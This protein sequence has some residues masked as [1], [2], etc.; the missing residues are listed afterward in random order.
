MFLKRIFQLMLI[1]L[2]PG[3]AA[4]QV[5]TGT[6]TGT[7]KTADGKIVDGAAVKAVHTPTGSV[8]TATSN[9]D[10]HFTLANVRVGGP[11]TLTVDYTGL[12]SYKV[13]D[14]NAALGTPLVVDVVLVEQSK[15]LDNVVVASSRNSIISSLHSGTAVTISSRQLQTLP[16]I[17]NSVQDFVRFMPQVKVGNSGNDGS[18]TGI[19]FGGQNNRY[20]QFT[21]DGANASDVFGLGSTGTNG[22]QANVNPISMEAIQELQVVM[23]PYDVAQGGFTGG[24]INAIT[25]SGTNK[26]HG[27]VY[28]QYQNQNFVGKSAGYNSTITRKDYGEFKNY[29]YGASL[30]GP[31][32]QNKLFFFANFEK[33]N[34]STPLAFDPTNS[35]SG[36]K[37]NPDTLE[38]IRQ[39]LISKYNYDPGSYGSI[40]NINKSTSVFARIDWNIDDKNKLMVRFNHVDGS[41]TI[42]SRSA[43][44][45]I[46]ANSGYGFT[47]K[48]NSFVAELNSQISSNAS[49]LLRIT[50]TSVRDARSTSRFPNVAI[51][52]FNPKDSAT[53][54]YNIGSDYSS[55]VNGLNQDV[56]T[57]TDNF[58]LY[59][60]NHTFTFGTNNTLYKSVNFF[61]QGYYGAYTYG[62]SSTTSS[63][64]IN[65][66]LNNTGLTTYQIGFSTSSTPGDKAPAT[67]KAGQFSLYAQDAWAITDKFRLTYGIRFDLPSFF[68]KPSANEAFASTFPG[69]TTNQMPKT[70]I[71]YS[72][73]V[74]FN[75]DVKGDAS[76]QL[77]GGAGLFTG[78]VPFVWV[79]N[80]ISNTGVQS[81]N[82]TYTG[83][84]ITS[85]NIT[86][87]ND[88]NSPNLGAF[89]P[90]AS[91]ASGTVINVID[92]KFKFPQVFRANLA[93]DQKLGFWGLIGTVEGV[94]TKTLNNANYQNINISQNGDSSVNIGP[95]SRPIWTK[96]SNTAYGNVLYL[97]NTSA[98]YGYNFT[99]QIQKPYS[100]GWSGSLAYT[101][102]HSTSLNDLTSS[103]AQSNWRSP[104][105]T[106]G[107]NNP[108]VSTSNFNMGSRIIGFISKEFRYANDHLSTTISLTYSGQ[109]GQ[110]FSYTYGNNILGDYTI[111]STSGAVALAYIPMGISQ[112][113]FVDIN[114]SSYKRTAAQQ[115]S[116]F[117]SFMLNNP[118]LKD[119]QGKVAKRNGAS[120]PWEN[121]FDVKISQNFMMGT[122]KLEVFFSV[123]NVGNM[124]NKNSGWSYG[125][126]SGP[127]GFYTLQSNLFSVVTSGSQTV[128]GVATTTPTKY[129]PAFQFNQGNFSQVKGV[130]RPYTVNDFTSRWNAVIGAKLSF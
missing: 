29:R 35:G 82:I 31:I 119:N 8:Y 78:N 112:A 52:N 43:T 41:N 97:T 48:N 126:G 50:Y 44:T 80:Q 102:G 114:T 108:D 14:I 58:N 42:L 40:N 79:S 75:W 76:M 59:K 98:G 26:F 3:I 23:S 69:Y 101:F 46:F 73:R 81:Q 87:T 124:I 61:L 89:V 109:S 68:N 72:P 67:L 129:N 39:Q 116:D 118:Y 13:D 10:G 6:I 49:N 16:T 60:G 99:F 110:R 47:D 128:N 7:V 93:L 22:G 122:N 27:N 127:D 30:G 64:N 117:Q 51:Y 125:S 4:A 100:Q 77:R 113:N 90:S 96:Y 28:G 45:A 107:L 94:F 91:T 66:F 32:I 2:L 20:N 130:Y 54:L 85:N 65:N 34:R 105:N 36:S 120:L 70:R 12:G 33:Y 86:F 1:I 92:K 21:I 56:W 83:T 11:Y 103:V 17:N 74:G 57:L 123:L 18:S 88:Q 5:T 115:W 71:M 9:N 121:H 24:G 38:Y 19:S 15:S 37:V 111:N 63:A 95:T 62:A 106:Y 104:I 84:G 55:A 25:K 53:I